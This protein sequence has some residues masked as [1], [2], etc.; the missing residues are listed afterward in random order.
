MASTP[1]RCPNQ[2]LYLLHKAIHHIRHRPRPLFHYRPRSGAS[3]QT[4]V[5]VLSPWKHPVHEN[6][7]SRAVYN[8][9]LTAARPG[10]W[11]L[12]TVVRSA[13]VS[14]RHF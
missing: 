9:C 6:V 8:S 14:R 13:A 12:V 11:L 10:K 4:L 7:D 3:K 5:A 2:R 1:R